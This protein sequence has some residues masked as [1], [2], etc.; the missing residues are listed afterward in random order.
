MFK[1]IIALIVTFLYFYTIT[2]SILP[3]STTVIFGIFGLIWF[4]ILLM[5]NKISLTINK[6][7][8]QLM[9]LLFLI[10]DVSMIS[11]VI[12]STIDNKFIS[13]VFSALAIIFAS[14]FVIKI[15]KK[16]EYELSF[17]SIGKLIINVIFIQ[18]IIALCMFLIPELKYFLL[19][20]EKLTEVEYQKIIGLSEFRIFGIGASKTFMAGIYNGYGLILMAMFLRM[21][22]FSLK[23]LFSF[24]LKFLIIFLVGM[25]MARTT[26]VGALLAITIIFMPKDLKATLSMFRKRVI[27]FLLFFLAPI[28]IILILMNFSS[29]FAATFGTSIEY[30]FEMFVNYFKYGS[31]ETES[32]N[33]L[34]ESY[35][36]PTGAKTWI[37]GD[38]YFVHPTEIGQYYMHT[39][40]GYFRLIYYF[41]IVGL[42]T[43][44]AMQIGLIIRAYKSFNIGAEIYLF[45][46][47]YL[48]ILN[49]K[50]FTDL[51]F[52]HV[53]FI[54]AYLL[55]KDV[56]YNNNIRS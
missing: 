56:K 37:I 45:V 48:L 4:V 17:Q 46:V 25:M 42:F 15:L 1:N 47:I 8:M 32:T 27:F 7:I 54:M 50:G 33:E 23:E 5:Q 26:L 51:L 29:S 12:N 35:S 13:Y 6:Y 9:I 55:N 34:K 40:V 49:L 53:L 2:F 20:L 38:G 36:L 30:G 16:I 18:S 14:Y 19:G 21:Y 39:D 28:V 44:L 52:I 43:Y 41:G 24:S 22:K 10:G 3:F 11:I 31:F